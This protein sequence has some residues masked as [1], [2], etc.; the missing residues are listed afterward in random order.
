[1]P[2]CGRWSQRRRQRREQPDG[3]AGLAAGR[4]RKDT[5]MA[6]ATV[7][8]PQRFGLSTGVWL[9]IVAVLCLIL[10]AVALYAG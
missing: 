2:T 4:G 5:Q 1:M 6:N 9:I 7:P 3:G 8:T 10:A